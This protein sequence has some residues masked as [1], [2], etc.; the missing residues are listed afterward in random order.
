MK[1]KEE[2]SHLDF[3]TH[4]EVVHNVVNFIK[5]FHKEV[6]L[7]EEMHVPQYVNVEK[8]GRVFRD[9]VIVTVDPRKMFDG[10]KVSDFSLE[11]LQAIGATN[12]LNPVSPM[13]GGF[14]VMDDLLGRADEIG[15]IIDANFNDSNTIVNSANA[16]VN[17]DVVNANVN[18]ENNVTE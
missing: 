16:V 13:S 7:V 11:N 10:L 2:K 5:D 3:D 4:I 6:S 17:N 15:Q 1:K 12:L 9:R 8:N 18:V 14:A